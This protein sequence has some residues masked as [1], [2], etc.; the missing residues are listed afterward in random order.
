M[1]SLAAMIPDDWP[2]QKWVRASEVALLLGVTVYTIYNWAKS[3]RL[4]KGNKLGPRTM[5][6]NVGELR[7]AL[8]RMDAPESKPRRK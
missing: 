8:Q 2:D 3:G 6:F 7:Q 5:L 1:V 4:P